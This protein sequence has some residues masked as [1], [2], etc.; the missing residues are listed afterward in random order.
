MTEQN[1]HRRARR[2]PAWVAL[3]IFSIVVLAAMSSRGFATAAEKWAI[4]VASISVTFSL[5]AT[6]A[7]FV[8]YARDKIVGEVPEGGLS[9]FLL[10]LWIAGLPVIMNPSKTIAVRHCRL[11]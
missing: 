9:L 6:V 4:A 11:D 7:Y 5:F 10:T 2:L 3:T 1:I 8:P